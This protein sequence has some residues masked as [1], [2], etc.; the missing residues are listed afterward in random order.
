MEEKENEVPINDVEDRGDVRDLGGK[1]KECLTK[2]KKLLL[3]LLCACTVLIIYL[4][5]I[6]SYIK[7]EED[8]NNETE[9]ESEQEIKKDILGRIFCDYSIEDDKEYNILYKDFQTPKYF[10]IFIDNNRVK[11][12]SPNYKIKGK[13]DHNITYVIYEKLNMSNMFKNVQNLVS[14]NMVS[15]VK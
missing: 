8:L 7:N 12:F 11:N 3:V 10:S 15:N 1:K 5:V 14:I 4:L 13:G 9:P 2:P 6:S